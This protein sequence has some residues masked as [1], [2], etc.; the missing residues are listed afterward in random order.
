MD[1][2]FRVFIGLWIALVSVNAVDEMRVAVSIRYLE[3]KGTSHTTF[4]AS[5]AESTNQFSML[6]QRCSTVL[7]CSFEH[8]SR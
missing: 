4:I 2:L 3:I 8:I 7:E 6:K 1:R 5:A